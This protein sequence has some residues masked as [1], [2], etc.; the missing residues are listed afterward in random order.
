MRIIVLE[1]LLNQL[2]GPIYSIML[3]VEISIV[4]LDEISSLNFVRNVV[5]EGI[6]FLVPFFLHA[7]VQI[8]LKVVFGELF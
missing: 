8:V 3:I 2:F 6:G 7:F 4:S 5:L 1:A